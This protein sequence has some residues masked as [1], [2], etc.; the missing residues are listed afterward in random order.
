MY[1]DTVAEKKN[2]Y[3]IGWHV[4]GN[5]DTFFEG[6]FDPEDD[7]PAYGNVTLEPTFLT[8]K[9]KQTGKNEV[10]IT[11]D[12]HE[13]QVYYQDIVVRYYTDKAK[14]SKSKWKSV[15]VLN[16][17]ESL[18]F[19]NLKKGKTYY[20]E[21]AIFDTDSDVEEDMVYIQKE[22]EFWNSLGK[23]TVK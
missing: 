23:I 5:D 13:T 18:K 16:D 19:K 9:K 3:F 11:F 15:R 17:T 2:S 8:Y 14:R 20:F 22:P 12:D 21:F 1:I 6:G 4:I 10:T 7:E